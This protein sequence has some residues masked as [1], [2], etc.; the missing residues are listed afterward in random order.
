MQLR[1]SGT[2]KHAGHNIRFT[3]DAKWMVSKNEKV[4]GYVDTLGEVDG[5]ISR[6]LEKV[7]ARLRLAQDRI[8]QQQGQE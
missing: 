3:A 4:I 7:R 1:A 8:A 6:Q 2:I 5:L